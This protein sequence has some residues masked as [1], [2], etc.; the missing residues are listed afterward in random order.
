MLET[1]AA[2]K[3]QT[4]VFLDDDFPIQTHRI[5]DNDLVRLPL[6]HQEPAVLETPLNRPSTRDL[7]WDDDREFHTFR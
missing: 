4:E 5:L 6:S 1:P 2:K 7:F 3:E